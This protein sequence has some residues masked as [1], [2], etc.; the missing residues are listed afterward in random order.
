MIPQAD[1][2][3][4]QHLLDGGTGQQQQ[5]DCSR[6]CVFPRILSHLEVVELIARL[7]PERSRIVAD[8]KS[9]RDTSHA[10]ARFGDEYFCRRQ[11][12]PREYTFYK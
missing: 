8:L 2:V 9:T 11:I 5:I 7:A 1:A 6:L 10:S 3:G 12:H 4:L